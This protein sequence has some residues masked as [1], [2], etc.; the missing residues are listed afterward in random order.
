MG[1]YRERSL[2]EHEVKILSEDRRSSKPGEI[3]FRLVT[4]GVGAKIAS[5][6]NDSH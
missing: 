2:G 3:I 5:A 4:A 6:M 1:A